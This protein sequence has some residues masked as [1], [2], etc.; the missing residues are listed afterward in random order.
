MSDPVDRSDHL[1]RQLA[2]VKASSV[3]STRTALRLFLVLAVLLLAIL[4]G[5]VGIT[6]NTNGAVKDRAVLER[7]NTELEDKVAVDEDLL[8]QATDAIV[9]LIETLQANGISPPEVI[10][11]PTTTVPDEGG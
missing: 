2:V 4:G 9:L 10:I 6:L 3:L 5:V 11:R 8:E 1:D 7:R